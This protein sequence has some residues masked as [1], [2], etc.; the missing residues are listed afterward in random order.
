MR[1]TGG[2]TNLKSQFI[3][4]DSLQWNVCGAGIGK[5]GFT[6]KV[7]VGPKVA[8]LVF[9]ELSFHFLITTCQTQISEL[10][11]VGRLIR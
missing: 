3:V 4:Y 2:P 11:C 10:S 8:F 5:Q 7:V 6:S 9:S 1:S